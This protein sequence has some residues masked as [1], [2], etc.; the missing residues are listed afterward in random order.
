MELVS[1]GALPVQCYRRISISKEDDKPGHEYVAYD[2]KDWG[3]KRRIL[4]NSSDNCTGFQ[5]S[6]YSGSAKPIPNLTYAKLPESRSLIRLPADHMGYECA[7]I[8]RSWAV[9][10]KSTHNMII[11]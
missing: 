6:S 8:R 1:Q 4:G 5:S 3:L 7:D 10:P 11:W 9:F 2:E